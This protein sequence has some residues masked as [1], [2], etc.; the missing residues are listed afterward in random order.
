MQN[1]VTP[2][3]ECSC[4][5]WNQGVIGHSHSVPSL[6]CSREMCSVSAGTYLLAAAQQGNVVPGKKNPVRD[7]CTK[8]ALTLSI[9]V[10]Y[11]CCIIVRKTTLNLN[12]CLALIKFIFPPYTF[13]H[14]FQYRTQPYQK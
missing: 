4:V 12:P 14:R 2:G 5:W 9:H 11:E 7:F 13:W 6:S 3:M 8:K 10:A 1:P